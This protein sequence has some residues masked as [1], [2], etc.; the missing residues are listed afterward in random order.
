MIVDFIKWLIKVIK[1]IISFFI[2][3]FNLRDAIIFGVGLL[4]ILSGIISW[5]VYYSKL[6]TFKKYENQFLSA[7]QDFYYYHSEYL[8]KNGLLKTKTLSEVYEEGR[9]EE[10]KI[11]GTK[12][13]CDLDSWVKVYNNNGNY[14]YKVYLKCDKFVSKVDYKGPEITL[15]GDSTIYVSLNHE[16]EELGVEKVVD[17]N[18]GIMDVSSV[19]IDSSKVDT[20]KVGKYTVTYTAKDSLNNI[21]KVERIVYV[22]RN[23][24]T[25]VDR[26][27]VV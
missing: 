25:I 6:F 4:F 2:K 12:D 23:L 16:Y 10:L 1:K 24:T 8:P 11:K 22:A 14:E 20:K 7:V 15:N 5:N 21:S 18:D 3:R 19:I 26:K 17:N 13:I 27:S 9:L